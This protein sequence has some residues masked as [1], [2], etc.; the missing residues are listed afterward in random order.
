MLSKELKEKAI[1]NDASEEEAKHIARLTLKA[2]K[3]VVRQLV[4]GMS[5]IE[6][7]EI[8]TRQEIESFVI[9]QMEYFE[10]K[11]YAMTDEEYHDYLAELIIK[12]ARGGDR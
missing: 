7:D 5:A 3:E 9:K 11:V 6:R 2:L 12:A 1:F 4:L 8:Y 10:N